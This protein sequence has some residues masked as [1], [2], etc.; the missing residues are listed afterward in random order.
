M[1]NHFL[2]K[3]I[4]DS[5]ED[6]K[7]LEVMRAQVQKEHEERIANNPRLMSAA[8]V[9]GNTMSRAQKD[10]LRKIKVLVS[11]GNEAQVVTIITEIYKKARG[12]PSAFSFNFFIE[13]FQI[14]VQMVHHILT[15]DI[16]ELCMKL[17][18]NEDSLIKI[19]KIA[20]DGLMKSTRVRY[21]I[22]QRKQLL[23]WPLHFYAL[24]TLK[25][26]NNNGARTAFTRIFKDYY[27]NNYDMMTVLVKKTAYSTIAESLIKNAYIHLKM[28]D[29]NG[30]NLA[31]HAVR[32]NRVEILKLLYE[33]E[34][35]IFS[36]SA[37]TRQR[38]HDAAQE[39]KAGLR[40]H[41]GFFGN[42]ILGI[43]VKGASLYSN[44]EYNTGKYTVMHIAVQ[45]KAVECLKFLLSIND[46]NVSLLLKAKDVQGRTPVQY[47][48]TDEIKRLLQN[49]PHSLNG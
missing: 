30:W 8:S 5:N 10:G 48:R 1:F 25:Y 26:P 37:I 34:K 36:V 17:E 45:Y 13:L 47:A 49:E 4:K 3:P 20:E 22:W 24:F 14:T 2:D 21:A 46:R 12:N 16:G 31:H 18:M 42:I 19:P 7:R 41:A 43:T 33:K 15:P 39:L 27:S 38:K 40:P 11:Q 29:E 44:M 32:Y 9:I 23:L 35:S 28:V 6:K